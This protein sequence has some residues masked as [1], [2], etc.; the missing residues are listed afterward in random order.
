MGTN[1]LKL[2]NKNNNKVFLLLVERLC[3]WWCC[4]L[5]ANGGI[6]ICVCRFDVVLNTGRW[7]VCVCGGVDSLI[8]ELIESVFKMSN[9]K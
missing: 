3:I 4:I 5:K 6:N 7:R 2:C 8:I 9:T 1:S